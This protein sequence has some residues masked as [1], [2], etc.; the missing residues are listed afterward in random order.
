MLQGGTGSYGKIFN[1]SKK[2]VDNFQDVIY[3]MSCVTKAESRFPKTLTGVWLSLAR[4]LDLGSRGRRFE[5]CHPDSVTAE[6]D[7]RV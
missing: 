6:Y 4:V 7:M 5:S 2:I 3:N 1:F